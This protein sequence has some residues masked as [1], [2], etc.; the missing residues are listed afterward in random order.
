MKICTYCLVAFR[1]CV[2]MCLT[3][4]ASSR[5][6]RALVRVLPSRVACLASV[7]HGHTLSWRCG[8]EQVSPPKPLPHL[9]H[10]HQPTTALATARESLDR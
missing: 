10:T 1:I 2:V 8:F 5:L 4:H 9:C 6:R 3:P 7:E